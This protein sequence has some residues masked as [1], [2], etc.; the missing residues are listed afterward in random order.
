MFGIQDYASFLAA[1]VV[2]QLVP[3]AGTLAILSATARNGVGAGFGAVLG[4]LAGDLLF[5]VAAVAGLAA[6]LTANPLLLQALQWF[7]A[8]YLCWLGLQLLRS[9]SPQGAASGEPR[10]SAWHC[11][12]QALAVSLANP[13]VVLFFM[14]FFPLF[15]RPE[16]SGATLVV[17]MAHVTLISFVYQ[18]GLVL[19]GNA[20]A[21]RLRAFPAARRIASGLAGIALIGFGVKLAAEQTWAAEQAPGS[22]SGFQQQEGRQT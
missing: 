8:A 3:G 13:K 7:G 9:P 11:F 4:T 1:I 22:Y 2:F 18:T 6:V 10:H 12:R 20:V 14:A 19:V 15:L 16:S 21:F 17:M 5:M